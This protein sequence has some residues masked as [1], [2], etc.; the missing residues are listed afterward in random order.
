MTDKI[1]SFVSL[2]VKKEIPNTVEQEYK[3][4]NK[5]N[6]WNKQK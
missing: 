1:K 5:N 2:Q 6:I 3:R 4:L